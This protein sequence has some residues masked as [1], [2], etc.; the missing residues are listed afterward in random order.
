MSQFL[1]TDIDPN[2]TNAAKLFLGR[3]ADRFD[4]DRAVLYGSRARRTHRIDS[5]A[6]IA[7][8]ING[9]RGDSGERVD[10]VIEM[11]GIAFDVM[12]DTGILIQALPLWQDEYAHP[13]EFSNP[14]LIENIQRE[15]V[16]L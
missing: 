6:D 10:A 3:I 11:A 5:D 14:A 9:K 8:I 4:V 2:T 13:E 15:G 1:F 16:V 12:L 7:I